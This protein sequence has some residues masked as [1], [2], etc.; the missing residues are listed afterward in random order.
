MTK[1][2]SAGDETTVG[3]LPFPLS[4]DGPEPGCWQ[5]G[6]AA[7]SAFAPPRTDLF[8]DPAADPDARPQP[9]PDAPRLVGVPTGDF[10]LVARVAVDFR[11]TFDAG[12]LVVH[13]G[14]DRWAKLC[15][16][17]T[18]QETPSV[19]TVV[20]RG[21]SDDANAVE[22]EDSSVWLRVS[23]TGRAYAFHTST[24]RRWWRMVRYF[25]LGEPAD[26]ARVGFLAQSPMGEGC[27]VTF[28][29]LEYRDHAP[30]DLRDGS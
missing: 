16:E 13:A 4:A 25:G 18:P 26:T 28:D 10:Q 23:R 1:S 12:V 22:T 2:L 21:E 9:L 14:P 15:F 27:P 24:D 11:T 20:T 19:V 17:Y 5:L 3:P 29:D 8:L 30:A 6:A 7:V